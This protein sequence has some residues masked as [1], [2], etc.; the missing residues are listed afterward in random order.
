MA[1]SRWITRATRSR[2]G[3]PRAAS[4]RFIL[5]Y[6]L[7]PRYHHPAMLQDVLQAI[8][9][10]AI[11][12]GRVQRQVAIASASWASRP[13]ATSRLPAATL[14]DA[15]RCEGAD[16]RR[17]RQLAARLRG[18]R[19]SGDPDGP[20]DGAHRARRTTCSARTRRPISWPSCRP[21]A[22]HRE[23]AADVPLPH[24]RGHR[25][26]G[27]ERVQFYLALRKAGVPA[28]LHIYEKG[29][30]GVG[31][32]PQTAKCP[33]GPTGCSAGCASTESSRNRVAD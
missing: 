20:A 1:A 31:L 7:G 13:A 6:R 32:D 25:R 33:P 5:K 17:R 18:A 9:V 28:E 19:L 11:A 15:P 30:H 22:G 4:R 2:A 27:G 29:P 24:E 14:F 12:R 23:H 8:R 21:T 16:G 26:A 3:S 10:V